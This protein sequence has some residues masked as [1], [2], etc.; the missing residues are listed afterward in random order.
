VRPLLNPALRA[1]WRDESTLQLGADTERATVLAGLDG[2]CTELLTLLDGTRTRDEL[3]DAAPTLGV[4]SGEAGRLIEL[5][6]D[7]GLLL[8]AAR[9]G[10]LAALAEPERRRLEPDAASWSLDPAGAD[11]VLRARRAATVVVEG[12]GRVGAGLAGLLAAAAVGQLVVV[13]DRVAGP[14]DA[15]PGGPAAADGGTG[16]ADSAAR[17]AERTA[18]CTRL[19][20]GDRAQTWAPAL[21]VLTPDGPAAPLGRAEQLLAADVPHLM[22]TTFERVAVVG[23][24]VLPGRSP[25][26]TCLDLH[27]ADRDR[28]WPTVAAQLPGRPAPVTGVRAAAACDV[29]LA[30]YATVLATA[31][32]LGFLDDPDR[33]HELTGAR[34]ELRPPALLPRRRSWGVHPACGCC[35][36]GSVPAG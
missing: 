4:S 5:L 33:Q 18:P 25:C 16:R 9:P 26:C 35:W 29:V 13:D 22:A 34:L 21:V 2:P 15:G 27:R 32:V 24:L 8:D 20:A 10:P 11:R 17:A 1:L 30:A 3:V 14:A 6:D 28:H 19:E 23:P 12:A 7:S 36:P 31:A